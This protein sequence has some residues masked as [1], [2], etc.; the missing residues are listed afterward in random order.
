VESRKCEVCGREAYAYVITVF[1]KDA[2]CEVCIGQYAGIT[3]AFIPFVPWS[4]ISENSGSAKN[5]TQ[6]V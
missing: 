6:H 3:Q 1:S 5:S 2:V 4:P